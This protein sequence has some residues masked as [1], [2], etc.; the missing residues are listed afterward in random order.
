[1]SLYLGPHPQ[2]KPDPGAVLIRSVK[3]Y[4]FEESG[5]EEKAGGGADW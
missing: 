4:I 1:M 2:V 3:A 5:D